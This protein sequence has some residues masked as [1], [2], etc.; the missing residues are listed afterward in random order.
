MTSSLISLQGAGSGGHGDDLSAKLDRRQSEAV[1]RLGQKRSIGRLGQ[2]RS[3]GQ[4]SVQVCPVG[5][6]VG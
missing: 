6:A 4:G 3:V 2:K 1:G 5:T